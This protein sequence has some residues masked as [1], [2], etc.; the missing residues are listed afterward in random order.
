MNSFSQDAMDYVLAKVTEP[1]DLVVMNNYG[2]IDKQFNDETKL[3]MM[4]RLILKEVAVFLEHYYILHETYDLIETINEAQWKTHINRRGNV[5]NTPMARSGTSTST[6]HTQMT[7]DPP[8]RPLSIKMSDFP[9]FNGKMSQ[10]LTFHTEFTSAARIYQMGDLLK[11]NPAHKTQ[12]LSDSTYKESCEL[13]YNLLNKAYARGDAHSKIKKYESTTDGYAAWHEL[14]KYYFAKGNIEAYATNNISDM[15]KLRLD[16][17]TPGGM[18][19]YI[20]RFE[21]AVN[22]LEEINQPMSEILKK[23][24]FL[25]GIKDPYY[26]SIKTVCEAESHDLDKCISELRRVGL[27]QVHGNNE[28]NR[29]RANN[30][31]REMPNRPNNRSNTYRNNRNNQQF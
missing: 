10:W 21:E 23:T 30:A 11:E 5:E 12:L 18:E 2:E 6:V 31:R 8:K 24:F 13:L 9:T 4:K 14:V 17:N 3:P 27:Q 1:D 20:S 22:N 29:R 15:T 19:H 16:Y 7:V 28:N 26:R 25:Q